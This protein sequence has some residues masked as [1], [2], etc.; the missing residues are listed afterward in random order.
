M[1]WLGAGLW[2]G[3][4]APEGC[5]EAPEAPGVWL[6]WALLPLRE[7][8]SVAQG[9]GLREGFQACQLKSGGLH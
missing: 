6:V 2:K 8:G 5:S 1:G 7:P 4:R 3:T 9:C